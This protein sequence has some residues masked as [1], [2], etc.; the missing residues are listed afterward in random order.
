[1]VRNPERAGGTDGYSPGV[2][3]I[4]VD[5]RGCACGVGDK[6]SSDKDVG[7][8]SL[9]TD[10]SANEDGEDGCDAEQIHG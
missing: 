7:S 4:R 5:D 6:V 10:S 9:S 8:L 1:M 2:D 3:Q